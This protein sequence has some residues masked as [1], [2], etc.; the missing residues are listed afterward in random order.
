MRLSAAMNTGVTVYGAF[1]MKKTLTIAILLNILPASTSW[2]IE[3]MWAKDQ[4]AQD[5]RQNEQIYGSQ[6]MTDRERTEYRNKMQAATNDE[7]REKIRS[8]HHAL[9]QERAKARGVA[10]PDMPQHDKDD[11]GHMR[12]DHQMH[13]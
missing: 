6:L 9:M 13:D 3:E 1:M 2:S 11:G 5:A 12:R 10:L 8:E 4:T 7:E